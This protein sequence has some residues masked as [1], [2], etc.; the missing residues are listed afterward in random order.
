MQTHDGCMDR[1]IDESPPSSLSLSLSFSPPSPPPSPPP[2]LSL[3]L[4]PCLSV[5]LSMSVC[6]SICLSVCLSVFLSLSLPLPPL[7]TP[8]LS[9]FSSL[10]HPTSAHR[11]WPTLQNDQHT[12]ACMHTCKDM[13]AR[14]IDRCMHAWRTWGMEV[15]TDECRDG[16]MDGEMNWWWDGWRDG[17][18]MDK[19]MDGWTVKGRMDEERAGLADSWLD[20]WMEGSMQSNL[21][22][23]NKFLMLGR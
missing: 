4:C 11:I 17:R 18:S 9:Q 8:L 15:G 5:W 12:Q 1:Y 3:C 13:M 2:H 21:R 20:R 7:P 14:W 6:M 22:T 16:R 19:W 10:Q 23:K